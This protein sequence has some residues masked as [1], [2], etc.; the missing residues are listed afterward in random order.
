MPEITWPRLN[1]DGADLVTVKEILGHSDV[2]TTLRYAHTNR[3]AKRRAFARL[4]VTLVTPPQ[5]KAGW[6]W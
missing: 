4:G 5:K 1:R 6:A 3:D 2:K